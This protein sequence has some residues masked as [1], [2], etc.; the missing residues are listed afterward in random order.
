MSV[1][2]KLEELLYI[3][4]NMPK[5]FQKTYLR[6]EIAYFTNTIAVFQNF[7]TLY[8]RNLK[9]LEKEEKTLV[10]QEEKVEKLEVLPE[11]KELSPLPTATVIKISPKFTELFRK[12]GEILGEVDMD[13]FYKQYPKEYPPKPLIDPKMNQLLLD[14][15]LEPN[16]F[17]YFRFITHPFKLE[18]SE[19][20]KKY[21]LYFMLEN[22]LEPSIMRYLLRE[23]NTELFD[24]KLFEKEWTDEKRDTEEFSQGIERIE[25]YLEDLNDVM[26]DMME[27]NHLNIK[28]E[29][30]SFD[31]I[32]KSKKTMFNPEL[33]KD[34][35][36][37]YMKTWGF[38]HRP[39]K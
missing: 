38:C 6:N 2:Q 29:E 13:S 36:T 39:V 4:K 10:I 31:I 16:K 35:F 14:I 28:M 24:L 21:I 9:E 26:N 5:D 12:G 32:I 34:Y 23:T 22:E 7:I 15:N 17:F 18:I 8:E 19:D 37:E 27:N 11:Q 25:K 30:L 3:Q 20:D 33:S 1:Q